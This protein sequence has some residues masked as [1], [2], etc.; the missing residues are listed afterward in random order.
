M[1][2]KLQKGRQPAFGQTVGRMKGKA[3]DAEK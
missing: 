2:L 3:I 1:Y